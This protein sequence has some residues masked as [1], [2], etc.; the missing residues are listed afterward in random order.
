MP[1]FNYFFTQNAANN[2]PV[3]GWSS[4]GSP[5]GGGSIGIQS[6]NVAVQNEPYSLAF[7]HGVDVKVL[8]AT[9][10]VYQAHL[11]LRPTFGGSRANLT[12][13]G[14]TSA[15]TVTFS[16]STGG[17]YYNCTVNVTV[18]HPNKNTNYELEFL[19]TNQT[20]AYTYLDLQLR[21]K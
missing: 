10:K 7:L 5:L 17:S 11:T 18:V 15:F 1:S 12:Y 16:P 8:K 19:A 21:V 4:M 20:G 2:T 13:S 9:T 14:P 6:A 3:S